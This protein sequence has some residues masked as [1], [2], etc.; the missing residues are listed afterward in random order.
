MM[1]GL[2][3][4][5]REPCTMLDKTTSPDGQGGFTRA[6][7]D[8]A[9]FHAAIVKDTSIEARTAEKQGLSEVYSVYV[10]KELAL[11]YHDVFRRNSDGAV[12]RV[13]SEIK[14]STTPDRASFSVGMVSA[15]RWVLT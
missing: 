5:A 4:E 14:D 6:W 8:G 11:E 10:D 12:F 15:E 2:M 9:S 1:I 13:T 3:A 7:V